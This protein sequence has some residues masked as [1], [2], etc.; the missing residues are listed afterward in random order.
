MVYNALKPY[1][2]KELSVHYVSNVDGA[3]IDDVLEDLDQETTLFIIASKTFTT[4][5]TITNAHIA[6]EW[7]LTSDA[8][9]SDVSQHFVAV[10]TNIEAATEFGIDAENMFEFWDWVGGR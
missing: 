2:H 1:H 6:R 8:K 5:E 3:H 9:E 7:F 4:Q 10:S